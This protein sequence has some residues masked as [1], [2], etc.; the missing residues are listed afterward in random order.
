MGDMPVWFKIAVYVIV[1]LTVLY[2]VWGMLHSFL[3]S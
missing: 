2:A 3:Q 1:G